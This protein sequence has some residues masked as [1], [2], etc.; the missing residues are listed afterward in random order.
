MG[1]RRVTNRAL[2]GSISQVPNLKKSGRTASC[3]WR[4]GIVPTRRSVGTAKAVTPLLS[5]TG[6]GHV[7]LAHP[8]CG[9]A[10]QEPCTEADALNGRLYQLY[11]E[12][13]GHGRWRTPV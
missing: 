11:L 5:G 10:G 3:S 1:S 8:L 12:L 4:Q 7:Y 2:K 6:E 9:D 13:G